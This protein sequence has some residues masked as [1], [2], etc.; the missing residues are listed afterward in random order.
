MRQKTENFGANPEDMDM[1]AHFAIVSNFIDGVLDGKE[2]IAPAR[3][4][5]RAVD[6]VLSIY[7]SAE[8]RA[9]VDVPKFDM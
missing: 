4:A 6:L 9:W 2:L 7:Q 8:K 3:D 1:A 5:R